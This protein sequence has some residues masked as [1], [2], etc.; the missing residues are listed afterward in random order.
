MTAEYGYTAQ[1]RVMV[2]VADMLERTWDRFRLHRTT[3]ALTNEEYLQIHWAEQDSLVRRMMAHWVSEVDEPV[4]I[5]DHHLIL[6]GLGP[7]FPWDPVGAHTRIFIRAM[8]HQ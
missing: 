7:G 6:L 2:D 3:R 4:V 1:P 5:Y 8:D